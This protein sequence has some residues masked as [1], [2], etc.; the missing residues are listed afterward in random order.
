MVFLFKCTC[1][2]QIEWEMIV[3]A[4]I[5]QLNTHEFMNIMSS[6]SDIQDFDDLKM[7]LII[8]CSCSQDSVC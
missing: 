4:K 1:K 6:L 3:F 7:Q 2:R 8:I 5:V